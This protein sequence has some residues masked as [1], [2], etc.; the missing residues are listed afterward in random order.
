MNVKHLQDLGSLVD[1][2]YDGN[3]QPVEAEIDIICA[4]VQT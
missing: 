2:L 4:R 1:K 3:H